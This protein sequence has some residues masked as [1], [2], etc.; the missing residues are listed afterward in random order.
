MQCFL[1][2]IYTTD[3][4]FVKKQEN[5]LI[6]LCISCSKKTFNLHKEELEPVTS[7]KVADDA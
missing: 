3:V 7:L 4:C 1:P 6:S 2:G 5:A